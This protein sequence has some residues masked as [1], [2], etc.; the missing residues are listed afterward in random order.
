MRVA[1]EHTG[2]CQDA[3][4]D[5]AQDASSPETLKNKKKRHAGETASCNL[6]CQGH[7]AG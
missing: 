2:C 4:Q 7:Q 1:A 3:D 6:G 5:A